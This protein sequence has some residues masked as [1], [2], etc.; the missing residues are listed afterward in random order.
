MQ[1]FTVKEV[2]SGGTSQ[3]EDGEESKEIDEDPTADTVI[4]STPAFIN[5]VVSDA[6]EIVF[7]EA[8]DTDLANVASSSSKDFISGALDVEFAGFDEQLESL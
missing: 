2:S 1:K 3:E 8:A 7:V 4:N 6:T 5:Y